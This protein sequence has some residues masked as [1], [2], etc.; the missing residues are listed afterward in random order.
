MA[1]IVIGP[2][3]SVE[4]GGY[5][6][7]GVGD[8]SMGVGT[9]CGVTVTTSVERTSAVGWGVQPAGISC[10]QADRNNAVKI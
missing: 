1:I 3:G 5:S 6:T 10:K 2:A 9:I 8:G 4:A 7:Y